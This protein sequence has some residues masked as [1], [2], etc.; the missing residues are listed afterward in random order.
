MKAVSRA[1]S[2]LNLKNGRAVISSN[3][4]VADPLP[5]FRISDLRKDLKTAEIVEKAIRI[6]ESFGTMAAATFLKAND[7]NFEVT[8]RVLN[9]PWQRRKSSE[10][11]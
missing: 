5:G 2:A 7:V 6:Q 1:L 11:E 9:R 10:S 3:E 4:S 8:F